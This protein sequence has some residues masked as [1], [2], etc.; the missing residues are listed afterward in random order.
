M[1]G[2][3]GI[4]AQ[5]GNQVAKVDTVVRIDQADDL[6]QDCRQRRRVRAVDIATEFVGERA[7]RQAEF[8]G[9]AGEV[10]EDVQV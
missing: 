9:V 8:A 5:G 1:V 4:G 10:A 3:I 7:R 6:G 2:S